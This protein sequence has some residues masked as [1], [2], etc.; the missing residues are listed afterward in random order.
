MRATFQNS[1]T[2]L[3]IGVFFSLMIIGLAHTLPHTLTNGLQQQGVPANIAQQVGQLPP[4]SSVFASFLGG[5][6]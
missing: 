6:G 4:V 3:S 1:G 5:D 2:S